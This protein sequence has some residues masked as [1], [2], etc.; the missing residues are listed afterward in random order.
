MSM[1]SDNSRTRTAAVTGASSGLGRAIAIG[2]GQLGWS[3]VI[4][5]RRVDRLHQTAA[6]VEAAGGRAIPLPL[7]VREPDSVQRF[8]DRAAEDTPSSTSS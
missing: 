2:F 1:W 8:F 4:G 6:A 3:V 5:A 7:D